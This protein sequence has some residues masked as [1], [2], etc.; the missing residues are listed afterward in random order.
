MP[1][2]G[3]SGSTLGRSPWMLRRRSHTASFTFCPMNAVLRSVSEVPRAKTAMV[4]CGLMCFS[5]GMA[6]TEAY[7]SSASLASTRSTTSMT[8]E[9][10]R[11]HRQARY[12]STGLPLN[13]TPPFKGRTRRMPMPLSSSATT[14]SKPK[15]Q[16]AKN[17]SKPSGLLRL[18]SPL[19]LYAMA[20]SLSASAPVDPYAR[21]FSRAFVA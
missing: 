17:S 16:V 18:K 1:K 19:C 7:S 14:L 20:S 9:A 21:T 2:S 4:F 5:Q 12:A 10:A 13:E 11:D 3:S 8:R 6:R 15:G